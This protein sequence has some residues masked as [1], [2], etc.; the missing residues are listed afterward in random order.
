MLMILYRKNCT[1]SWQ[2]PVLWV[3][4]RSFLN[5][6]LLPHLLNAVDKPALK[7]SSLALVANWKKRLG[8]GENQ[9]SMPDFLIQ[10]S[11]LQTQ[12]I[13]EKM[14]QKKKILITPLS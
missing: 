12:I 2:K 14:D 3:A 5:V 6:C 8:N 11:H 4:L 7:T 13:T 9:W 10:C 1:T